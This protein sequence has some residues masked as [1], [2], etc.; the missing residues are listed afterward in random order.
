[1][2][3]VKIANSMGAARVVNYLDDFLVVADSAD[4]CLSVRTVVIDVT[5]LLGFD[6]SLK[7]VTDPSRVRGLP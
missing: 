6:V 7:K 5:T 3:I 2:F 4:D 1:M